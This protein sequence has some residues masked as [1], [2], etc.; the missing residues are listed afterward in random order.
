MLKFLLVNSRL[1]QL[2][3]DYLGVAY[4]YRYA[5]AEIVPFEQI[6]IIISPVRPHYDRVWM[7][8][9]KVQSPPITVHFP[10]NLE[11]YE[12]FSRAEKL[13]FLTT[14]F[15]DSL[16]LLFKEYGYNPQVIQ[17]TTAEILRTNLDMYFPIKLL[18]S[19]KK[20]NYSYELLVKPGIEHF[21]FYLQV[22]HEEHV[23]LFE[24]F[25]GN[26]T[27]WITYRDLFKK[28]KVGKDSILIFGKS[29][30]IIF[31]F[32]PITK[33]SS[34]YCE[35]IKSEKKFENHKAD[36]NWLKRK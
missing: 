6:N 10:S 13:N 5:L 31:I 35:D 32:N 11:G 28:I 36:A 30:D 8:D 26:T 19:N 4:A 2:N 9:K 1:A 29:K 18:G 12:N 20:G 16:Q 15:Q 7:V 17:N 14:L 21:S 22:K 25:R 27:Y 34:V 24:I 3:L 23:S 33:V